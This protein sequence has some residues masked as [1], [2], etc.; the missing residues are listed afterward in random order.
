MHLTKHTDYALRTL[1]YLGLRPRRRVTIREIAAAYGISHN[2]LMKVVQQLTSLDYID[3]TRGAG[4]GIAL[5]KSANRVS[6]GKLVREMEGE[7]PV[8]ECFNER[9]TCLITEV[10]ELQTVLSEALAAFLGVLDRYT[11]AHLVK[12]RARLGPVL[13]M[14]ELAFPASPALGK[15]KRRA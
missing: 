13:G 14:V 10:C 8:V 1:M 4:G 11:L 7:F 5:S 2:H 6:L 12:D 15:R 9:G 3:S